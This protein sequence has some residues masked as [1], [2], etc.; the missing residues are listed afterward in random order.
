[1]TRYTKAKEEQ[2]AISSEHHINIAGHCENEMRPSNML[3]SFLQF[4]YIMKV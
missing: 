3:I 1:M 4:Y 2:Y